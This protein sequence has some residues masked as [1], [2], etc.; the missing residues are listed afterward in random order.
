MFGKPSCSF[1]YRS[2]RTAITDLS[3]V[4]T[5]HFIELFSYMERQLLLDPENEVHLF[6]LHYVFIPRINNALTLFTDQWNKHSIR[7]ATI[8]LYNF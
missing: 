7:T 2:K 3:G 8:P 6:A 5:S 4:V 1:F